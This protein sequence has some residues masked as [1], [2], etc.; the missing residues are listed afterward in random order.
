L[1]KAARLF[2]FLVLLASSALVSFAQT[3]I[4]PTIITHK[5]DP[6]CGDPGVI[7][8]AGPADGSPANSNPL[9]LPFNT[10]FSVIFVYQPADPAALLTDFFLD[11][12]G[13]PVGTAFQCETNIWVNC[14]IASLGGGVIQFEMFGGYTGTLDPIGT[15][16][17]KSDGGVGGKCPGYLASGDGASVTGVPLISETPEP[18]SLLLFG[19]GLVSILA[20]VRRRFHT[21][22]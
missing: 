20:T 7:C 11:F 13:V 10:A 8:Y 1:A 17:C 19:T 3:P 22:T 9:S 5:L 4:D 15:I 14:T 18:A 12:T 21:R 16:N 2:F 6:A